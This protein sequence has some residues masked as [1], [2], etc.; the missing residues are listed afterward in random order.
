MSEI[1]SILGDEAH[2][3]LTHESRTIPSPDFS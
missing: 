2:S 1:T 3:L